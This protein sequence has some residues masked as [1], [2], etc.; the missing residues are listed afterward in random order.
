MSFVN[1]IVIMIAPV[2]LGAC[3]TVSPPTSLE[4]V[5]AAGGEVVDHQTLIGT[6]G[7][8]FKATNGNWY[9]YLGPD[10]RKVVKTN[11]TGETKALTWRVNDAGQFCQQMFATGKEACDNLVLVKDKTGVYTSYNKENKKPGAT[12]TVTAG[13]AQNL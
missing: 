5:I 8:T 9:N 2:L 13:N 1:R 12:F 10:G 7:V 3:A 6:E 4:D 11:S